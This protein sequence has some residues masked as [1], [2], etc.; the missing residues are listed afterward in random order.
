LANKSCRTL[1][2]KIG[3]AGLDFNGDFPA[4]LLSRN[5]DISGRTGRLQRDLVPIV[6]HP[7]GDI[8]L[9]VMMNYATALGRNFVEANYLSGVWCQA[10]QNLSGLTEIYD[11]ALQPSLIYQLLL[12][13]VALPGTQI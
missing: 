1:W 12:N 3:P 11:L 10:E 6:P 13:P 5:I 2:R 7:L 4:I 8:I 9:P